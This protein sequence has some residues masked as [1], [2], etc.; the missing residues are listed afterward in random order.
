MYDLLALLLLIASVLGWILGRY[1][2]TESQQSVISQKP[3]YFRGLNFLLSEQ[4][5]KAIDLFIES[6][7]VTA[8]TIETHLALGNLFRRRGE[9]ERAIKIHQNIIAHADL[10]ATQY[11]AA[12][13]E[14]GQDYMSAGLIDRAENLH[15]ELINMG[16]Y[17]K[18][19][20][21]NLKEIYQQEKDWEK[22]LK[23]ASQLSN[24]TGQSQKIDSAHYYCEQAEEAIKI[25]Y[26]TDAW[27]FTEQALQMDPNCIRAILLKA[28]LAQQRRDYNAAIQYYKQALAQNP[29]F[30]S[31]TA[32]G[33]IAIHKQLNQEEAL[34]E[35][36]Y[37]LYTIQHDPQILLALAELET[38]EKKLADIELLFQAHLH[39]HTDLLTLK[40][41]IALLIKRSTKSKNFANSQE[42][43][44]I[45]QQ[46]L[47]QVAKDQQK[48][49]CVKCGFMSNHLHWQCPGCK[50]W[51]TIRFSA[52]C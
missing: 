21:Q 14:L 15:L 29:N 46:A 34:I 22:C 20:L 26:L 3:I 49:R 37:E 9:V 32:S 30:F 11:A 41:F 25:Y 16:F 7:E 47:D 38:S 13:L 18:P 45:I 24:V 1:S 19:A 17:L 42:L 2:K 44:K 28:K 39:E 6:L 23:I 51:G 48:Y 40:Y 52:D 8:E 43:L 10:T 4:P 33:L 31:E 50:R 5:D 12:L 36:L 35:Y 27:S